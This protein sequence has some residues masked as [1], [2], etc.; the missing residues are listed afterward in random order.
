METNNLPTTEGGVIS[1]KPTKLE[2]LK[3]RESFLNKKI[4]S[5]FNQRLVINLKLDKFQKLKGVKEA[6][7]A[8]FSKL[9]QVTKEK[10]SKHEEKLKSII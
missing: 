6:R 10:M 7:I 4:E 1:V 3:K 8:Y 9:L 5:L 2:K